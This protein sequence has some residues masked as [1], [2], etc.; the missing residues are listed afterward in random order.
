MLTYIMH[1]Q[2]LATLYKLILGLNLLKN[3]NF[4]SCVCI[5]RKKKRERERGRERQRGS[6]RERMSE[7]E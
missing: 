5:E 2:F 7:R 3:N 1:A 4:N 6:Q